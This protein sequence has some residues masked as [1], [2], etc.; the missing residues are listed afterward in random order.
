M[1]REKRLVVSESSVQRSKIIHQYI[2]GSLSRKDTA[3]ALQLSERQISRLGKRFQKRGILG[4]QHKS[5]G[6][7]SPRRIDEEIR[8]K[9][10][11]LLKEKYLNFNMKHFHEKLSENE[12]ISLSYSSVKRICSGLGLIK[13]PR[14]KRKI[15][16]YRNRHASMGLML[17]MD[18][19]DHEWVRGQIWCLIAGIDDASSEV[20]YA[21]FFKTESLEGYLAVLKQVFQKRGV[22]LIVYVDHAGWLSGTAWRENSG[23]FKRMCDE[24]G[25]TL[26]YADSPQAKGR[27]ERLWE[28]FQD[29][30]VAELAF[31]K[32]Q[33]MESANTFLQTDFLPNQWNK[34]FTVTPQTDRCAYRAAPSPQALE[35]IFCFKFKRKIRNDHTIL[36]ENQA[37]AITADLGFSIA[38]REAQIRIYKDRPM[39]AFCAGKDLEIKRITR[40][41][42]YG[43]KHPSTGKVDRPVKRYKNNKTYLNIYT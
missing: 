6:I 7:L 34:K 11:F 17:Q 39:K 20:P 35:E 28:T 40:P 13:R 3:E 16:K 29:R 1:L 18:G 30:L 23:Q 26:I 21:E 10:Q 38:K 24:L 32:C 43:R 5:S 19:S 42:E 36:W 41:A 37:W 25:I 2:D 12:K 4:L 15:R 31:Q 33:T 9:V 8:E 27:I 22:P 14:R